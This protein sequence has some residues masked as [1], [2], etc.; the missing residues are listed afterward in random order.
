[1]LL[2]REHLPLQ[3]QRRHL[4]P[5][6]LPPL[7]ERERAPLQLLWV[8]AEDPLQRVS[9]SLGVL[10]DDY[11][12][13]RPALLLDAPRVTFFVFSLQAGITGRVVYPELRRSAQVLPGLGRSALAR[14]GLP[15]SR[16]CIGM[17]NRSCVLR[18]RRCPAE[19]GSATCSVYR[20]I[21]CLN[22]DVADLWDPTPGVVQC[23]RGFSQLSERILRLLNFD[24]SALLASLSIKQKS[25]CGLCTRIDVLLHFGWLGHV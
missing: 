3:P 19:A 2:E 20:F 17:I 24:F 10:R 21:I 8:G 22:S 13:E 16:P 23:I 5:A 15:T 12:G 4:L 1:V 7:P 25:L 9:H 18:S 6:H 14:L 11:G